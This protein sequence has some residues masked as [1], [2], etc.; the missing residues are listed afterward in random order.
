M[1]SR[2]TCASEALILWDLAPACPMLSISESK[3]D[4]AMARHAAAPAK[5]H[6]ALP[7]PYRWSRFHSS[8]QLTRALCAIVRGDSRASEIQHRVDHLEVVACPHFE[9]EAARQ[10]AHPEIFRQNLGYDFLDLLVASHP[11]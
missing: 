2:R 11:D 6:S 1:P 4:Q 9:T 8:S 3:I 7:I 10:R 5:F